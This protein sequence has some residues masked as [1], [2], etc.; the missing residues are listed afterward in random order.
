VK[1][2]ITDHVYRP[3]A[4]KNRGR[5]LLPCGYMNCRRAHTEHQRSVTGWGR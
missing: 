5:Q 1:P 3:P 2:L 4:G